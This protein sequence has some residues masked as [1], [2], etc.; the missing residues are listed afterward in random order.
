MYIL[1]IISEV[2]LDLIYESVRTALDE[3]Y[4]QYSFKGTHSSINYYPKKN[5]IIIQSSGQAKLTEIGKILKKSLTKK[6]VDQAFLTF[7]PP[8]PATGGRLNQFISIKNG[9]TREESKALIHH[10]KGF[11]PELKPRYFEGELEIN[12]ESEES[13]EEACRQLKQTNFSF[14]FNCFVE[15]SD[16]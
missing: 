8:A 9:L 11:Y 2:N 13:I 14:P 1:H 16:K 3:V 15:N 10:I 5:E 6:G 7:E 4:S 12:S